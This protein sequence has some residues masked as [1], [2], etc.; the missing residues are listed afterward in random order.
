MRFK[1]FIVTVALAVVASTAYAD[2]VKIELPNTGAISTDGR[3]A[4]GLGNN[5]VI[6]ANWRAGFIGVGGI[7][8]E[9][10][11]LPNPSNPKGHTG[12]HPDISAL[13]QSTLL[14]RSTMEQ[15]FIYDNTA[16]PVSAGTWGAVSPVV[17]WIGSVPEY[18]LYDPGGGILGAIA[19][20]TAGYYAYEI[21]FTVGVGMAGLYTLY[22]QLAI[23]NGLV[24]VMVDDNLVFDGT[25]TATIWQNSFDM[26]SLFTTVFRLEEG[27][28]T[29]TF[30]TSN[31]G[32]L[33]NYGNPSGFW[34]TNIW[35]QDVDPST[36]PE[37]ATVL[38]FAAGLAGLGWH[39]R[40]T[41]RK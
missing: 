24:G 14:A 37:P 34:G 21:D 23:D 38:L 26:R 2:L 5:V 27:A 39:A 36:V 32:N 8:I 28:H 11:L 9:D 10:P 33:E 16:W 30:L 25:T 22:G 29:L 31:Y 17:S 3:S 19:T 4:D 15:A 40:K 41:R 1:H 12:A 7:G 20:H 18:S 35:F 13:Y 6:D